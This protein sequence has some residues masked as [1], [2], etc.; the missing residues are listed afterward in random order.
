MGV[1][2]ALCARMQQRGAYLVLLCC[3]GAWSARVQQGVGRYE[4]VAG[5]QHLRAHTR[6]KAIFFPVRG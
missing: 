2:E 3:G 6:Y 4:K 1:G 5:E